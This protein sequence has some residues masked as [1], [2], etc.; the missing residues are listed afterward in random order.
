[1]L[2]IV[3][4]R[5]RL[6]EKIGEGGMGEI[7]KAIDD[8]TQE[9]FALKLFWSDYAQGEG[10][11]R[12]ERECETI[13]QL[14]HTGIVKIMCFGID[15][16]R[17][18]IVMEMVH[19][20]TLQ[21]LIDTK[22][23]STDQVVTITLQ[24]CSTLE[25]I[26]SQHIIH[27]DVKPTNIIICEDG[28]TKIMDFG[29]AW[30]RGSTSITR[31]GQI[32][33][34]VAYISPEQAKGKKTDNRSDLYSL[35]V[36][37]YQVLTGK[38]PFDGLDAVSLIM[39]HTTL[40]PLPPRAINKDIPHPLERIVLK[41][42]AKNPGERFQS[43]QEL[44]EAL[45]AYRTNDAEKINLLTAGITLRADNTNPSL[46]N[47][48]NELK[49]VKNYLDR[50]FLR[51]GG[52]MLVVGEK[53]IG[54]S[55]FVQEV[56]MMVNVQ[57]MEFYRVNC[58]P[59]I[60]A[61][62]K[63][64]NTIIRSIGRDQLEPEYSK[65]LRACETLLAQC[66]TTSE[67]DQSLLHSI[68]DILISHFSLELPTILIFENLHHADETTIRILKTSAKTI[69]DKSL[70]IMGTVDQNELHTATMVQEFINDVTVTTKIQL[71]PFSIPETSDFLKNLFAL[72]QE[73]A[74]R[75]AIKFSK[76][77]QGNPLSLQETVGKYLQSKA[78][79]KR[80]TKNIAVVS[81]AITIGASILFTLLYFL[82]ED[83][84]VRQWIFSINEK[85]PFSRTSIWLD[86]KEYSKNPVFIPNT[87]TFASP[88]IIFDRGIYKMWYVSAGS[89]YYAESP[90]GISWRKDI[91]PGVSV[92]SASKGMNNFDSDEIQSV[93][94]LQDDS[95]YK[96][97]Y[98]G[99]QRDKIP[100]IG[101]AVS[102]DGI[103]WIKIPGAA[104]RGAVLDVGE[105]NSID[106]AGVSKPSVQKVGVDYF[107][108]YEG[109]YLATYPFQNTICLAKSRDG[110]IWKRQ[111]ENPVFSA[112]TRN[113]DIF[114]A[115]LVGSPSV[116]FDGKI[117][118]M[119]YYG[120]GYGTNIGHAV[121]QDGIKWYRMKHL[122]FLGAL[123]GIGQKGASEMGR[124]QPVVLCLNGE[125]KMWFVGTN[126]DGNV[127]LE[128]ATSSP[129]EIPSGNLSDSAQ[130]LID[131]HFDDSSSCNPW[132][133]IGMRTNKRYI[134]VDSIWSV[135]SPNSLSIV[136]QE[137]NDNGV[138]QYE[139]SFSVLNNEFIW[140][141]DIRLSSEKISGQ[142]ILGNTDN[143]GVF[144]TAV[145][146]SIASGELWS[147]SLNGDP[148]DRSIMKGSLNYGDFSFEKD[149][150]Y[151]IKTRVDVSKGSFAV[152]I[153]GILL[154]RC[155]EIGKYSFTNV[156]TINTLR[157]G[158]IENGK[159]YWIDNLRLI[160]ESN[161]R[162]GGVPNK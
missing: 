121:S 148:S 21:H 51:K 26:H 58:E 55:R 34:T 47:R 43:A 84:T 79:R 36:V 68:W 147:N 85:N 136:N 139:K 141:F 127:S 155:L 120:S 9:S 14:D 133:A 4:N 125:F 53:G 102:S 62:S 107:M 111:N 72:D 30:G 105:A 90:D 52:L 66:T 65:Q 93:A 150:W 17:C 64:V 142:W 126:A 114:D 33:G 128:F 75:L 87:K 70:L 57:M 1:M 24:L 49:I 99:F 103:R 129:I 145:D 39:G 160:T 149:K 135:S 7:F 132:K 140:E 159:T 25:Y 157:Y 2:T 98:S 76:K 48:E 46:I 137:E 134:K 108:W 11:Q 123:Y 146:F 122:V 35:G 60:C 81:L 83:V 82:P 130:V 18:Y 124:S 109:K 131:E 6:E 116:I 118:R 10:L 23:I 20:H 67:D 3:N 78:Q 45:E 97:W 8:Q 158:T 5:Y 63:M 27:R 104:Y 89:V 162:T 50:L 138:L 56:E 106:E 28:T 73:Y 88:S 71:K 112:A 69:A 19:G 15:N 119:W 95:T 91:S 153:N 38:L 12:F 92:L 115:R 61:L 96:M 42:L 152:W 40:T 151:R 32:M 54:K 31:T 74:E 161:K 143:A 154:E 29:L 77:C 101:Y 41:L 13:S 59:G 113:I 144:H 86:W 100:R 117:F 80:V 110:I 44:R 156:K 37:L 22:Q 16:G 94:V